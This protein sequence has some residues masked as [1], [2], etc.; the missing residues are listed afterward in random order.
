MVQIGS[1]GTPELG[2]TEKLSNLF[3]QGRT[4][5]GGSNL[6]GSSSA[7]DLLP[8]YNDQNQPTG[9]FKSPYV[10][11]AKSTSGGTV[12]GA[13]TS[14]AGTPSGG[15]STP[16]SSTPN[17]D[18]NADAARRAQ[19]AQAQRD[20]EI[21]RERQAI[22]GEFDPIFAELD[23]QLGALPGQK[24]ELE[25][26]L[27]DL[28][29]IQKEG[30]TADET[31]GITALDQSAA[32]ETETAKGSL[33]NLEEDVRNLLQAK[34]FYFGAQGAGDSSAPGMAS[35]AIT[36]GALKSRGSVL[37]ARDA[38]LADIE[39]KKQD[40]RNLSSDQ[41]RKID[42]WKSTKLYD[43]TE[44]F[45]KQEN[46]LNTAKANATG[47]KAKA[48]N[49]VI[50]GLSQDYLTQLKKLDDQVFQYKSA[51]STW[52]QQRE[53]DLEDYKTKL[54]LSSQYSSKATPT[55]SDALN[56]FN[57][58][59]GNGAIS[60]GDARKAVTDQYGI[61]PLSGLELTPDQ[62]GA[63]KKSLTDQLAELSLGALT[64]TPG[65]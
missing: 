21:A 41:S 8:V 46:D 11:P 65:Q 64:P 62:S 30:V 35:E 20:A 10:A 34:Q 33:R 48:I 16:S 27:S 32:K 51:V 5:Q 57:K 15:G 56:A 54:S 6:F 36:K 28:A 47:A 29:N 55:Y 2:L 59:Y 31:K 25:T 63:K 49:D 53:A 12:K 39:L 18:V 4:S 42:E 61:D 7:T 13:S 38:G 24:N 19:E 40:V 9:S 23:R 26:K 14:S 58:V 50:R 45:Q 22:S 60:L 17:F 44:S 3:G 43:L 37:S 52:Q 1:W